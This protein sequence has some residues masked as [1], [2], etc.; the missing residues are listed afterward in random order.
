M[1]GYVFNISY[2][3]GELG[4]NGVVGNEQVNI[5]GTTVTMPIGAANQLYGGGII[6]S[7]YDGTI[8]LGWQSQNSI[9]PT[10]QQT[11]MEGVQGQLGDPVFA[12]NF[13]GGAQN[14][15]QFGEADQSLY[16][17]QLTELSIDN[18]TSSYWAING[19]TFS[20]GGS[21]IGSSDGIT[22]LMD[23]GGVGTT[24]DSQ[25]ASDYWGLVKGASQSGGSWTFP[26][27]ADFPDLTLNFNGGSSATIPGGVLN[28]DATP[29][30]SNGMCTGGLQATLNGNLIFFFWLFT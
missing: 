11:F 6:D 4:A 7:T 25:T 18:S 29:S 2:D 28:A 3:T 30:G 21:Q 1:H 27:N 22:M 15:I 12:C 19:V 20:A 9:S 8:G 5:G 17:G 14:S 13:R 10:P 16:K 24:T 26:C 23:T